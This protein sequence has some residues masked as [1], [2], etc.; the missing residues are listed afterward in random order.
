MAIT[1]QS[2][3]EN[4][5][6]LTSRAP[7]TRDF[8]FDLLLAY[9]ISKSSVTRLRSTTASSLNVAENPDRD[10]VWKNK[11]YLAETSNDLI[12]TAQEMKTSEAAL[13]FNT[14][15]V[16]ATNYESLAAID[17]KTGDSL[18]IPSPNSPA[19]SP[20][21]SPGRIWRNSTS[22]RIPTRTAAPPNT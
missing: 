2:I 21:S 7:F 12:A 19:I 14:R 20:F 9:G 13:R 8:F 3:E 22:P 15:F 1:L 6:K 16:I 11:I 10:I 18:S 4:V 17:T 5:K